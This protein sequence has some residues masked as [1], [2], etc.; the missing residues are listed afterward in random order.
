MSMENFKLAH[1]QNTYMLLAS[2][3]VRNGK[4]WARGLVSVLKTEGTV[5]PTVVG[6]WHFLFFSLQLSEIFSKRTQMILGFNLH[7]VFHKL[8]NFLMSKW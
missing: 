3:E 2:R 4:N 6:E 1:S 8:N 7:K 5:F